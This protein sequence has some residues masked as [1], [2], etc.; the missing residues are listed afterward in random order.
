MKKKIVISGI[1]LSE[2]GPLTALKDCLKS[3]HDVLG[4]N[5]EIVALVHK[6]ELFNDSVIRFIEF[7]NAKRSWLIRLYYEWV[8]FKKISE[9]LK[10]DIWF[11]FHD[12][13]PNV[14]AKKRVVY[15]HNP[16]PFF[17]LNLKDFFYEP[18][19]LLF[20]KFYDY[21]YKINIKKNHFVIV[22]QGWI[23][24]EFQRR[25]QPNEVFVSYPIISDQSF[26]RIKKN[27]QKIDFFYPVLPRVFKNIELVCEAAS[28]LNGS[29]QDK[30]NLY[31]TLDGNENRYASYIFNKYS[32]IP[33]VRFVGRLSNEAM[34]NYYSSMDC[35]IF[36]S[37]ME[38]W[39]LPISEA[40]DYGLPILVSDLPF[41]HETVGNYDKVKFFDCLDAR[42]LA[43]IMES[44]IEGTIKYDSNQT[45]EEFKPDVSNWDDLLILITKE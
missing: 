41:A 20:N 11:S 16:S 5:W 39:G 7:P 22:Q 44:M 19:L 33:N 38:T 9:V 43:K 14:F 3:A 31:L 25:Y 30:F 8:K 21:L 27:N 42:S 29:Y 6:K 13:T 23:K 28:I 32:L 1:N 37:R 15:C 18:K 34:Q 2:G 36:P 4:G 45:Q 12:I 24:N 35:L 40:K 17:K 26:A 10:P